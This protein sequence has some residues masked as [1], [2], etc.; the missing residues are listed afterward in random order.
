MPVEVFLNSMGTLI[1]VR[2][3]QSEY[4][5]QGLWCGFTDSPLTEQGLAEA[6]EAG[7]AIKDQ[8]L[9]VVFISD[10]IRSKQTWEEM[11][12]VLGSQLVPVVAPEIKERDYGELAGQNKWDLK[13]KYG[14]EQWMKW[15]RSWDEVVPGGESLKDVFAR[16]IPYYQQTIEP[17]LKQGQTV[18]LSAHGNSLRALVKHLDNISDQDVEKL[19]IA[20]GGI[21]LYKI[22]EQG[23]VISK[24]RRAAIENKA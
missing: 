20:T 19:E 22:D 6:R 8:K 4:N 14:L 3:G 16:V 11:A 5:A 15:R 17:L 7:E 1:L 23:R 18:L 13:E 21:L 2:H 9:D 12:K 10:L 24:E